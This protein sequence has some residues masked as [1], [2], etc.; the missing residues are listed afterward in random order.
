[1]LATLNGAPGK[2]CPECNR[3]IYAAR[4]NCDCGFQ[5]KRVIKTPSQPSPPPLHEDRIIAKCLPPMFEFAGKV[6]IAGSPLYVAYQSDAS[7]R[8]KSDDL[9][10]LVGVCWR[11]S[12][13][14]IG[15]QELQKYIL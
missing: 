12:M 7:M 1:M 15:K 6:D 4:V 13:K 2:P 8:L 14:R 10:T 9:T 3:V 11:I 5:F